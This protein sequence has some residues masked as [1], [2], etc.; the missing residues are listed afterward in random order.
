MGRQLEPQP[1]PARYPTSRKFLSPV[2]SQEG[3]TAQ[4][5][6]GPDRDE[7]DHR[8]EALREGSAG[9]AREKALGLPAP[10]RSNRHRGDKALGTARFF[11]CLRV[12]FNK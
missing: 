8:N 11:T 4:T 9:K 7:D 1:L 12:F 3:V 2:T 6:P 5:P 10:L